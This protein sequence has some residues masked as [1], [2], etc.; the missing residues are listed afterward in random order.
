MKYLNFLLS[1]K[2][3]VYSIQKHSCLA[4][5]SLF[6]GHPVVLSTLRKKSLLCWCYRLFSGSFWRADIIVA[7]LKQNGLKIPLLGSDI[8]VFYINIRQQNVRVFR[9]SLIPK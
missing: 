3:D 4:L 2:K 9:K 6:F 8:D 1:M 7:R 5:V